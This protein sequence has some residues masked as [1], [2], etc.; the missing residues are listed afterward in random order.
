MLNPGA[1]LA[2]LVEPIVGQIV[3]GPPARADIGLKLW[4]SHNSLP[5]SAFETGVADR[6]KRMATAYGVS[7]KSALNRALKAALKWAKLM[8]VYVIMSKSRQHTSEG[9]R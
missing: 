4:S 8:D 9:A 5:C 6:A 3:A 2:E 7:A 1:K